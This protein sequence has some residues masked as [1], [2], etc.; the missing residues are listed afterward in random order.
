MRPNKIVELPSQGCLLF[1]RWLC[2]DRF[3]RVDKWN[4]NASLFCLA[5][6]TPNELK[7][8]RYGYLAFYLHLIQ[9]CIMESETQK[10]SLRSSCLS[11]NVDMASAA[12]K[13]LLYHIHHLWPE[14]SPCGWLSPVVHVRPYFL[15]SP[16]AVKASA[17]SRT[18]G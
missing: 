1:L 6:N 4:T 2:V 3:I 15:S 12:R 13:N 7:M 10:R 11:L 8:G 5:H 18:T 17:H 16:M 14:S 9:F